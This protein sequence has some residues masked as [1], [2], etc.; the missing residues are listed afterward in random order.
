M[1]GGFRNRRRKRISSK[2]TA[3]SRRTAKMPKTLPSSVVFNEID[4]DG[5][6]MDLAVPIVATVTMDAGDVFIFNDEAYVRGSG[7]TLEEAMEDFCGSFL[8]CYKIL[9]KGGLGCNRAWGPIMRHAGC[10]DGE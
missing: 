9:L 4:Y 7:P 10:L 6:H 8:L 2:N 5:E 3:A 1:F